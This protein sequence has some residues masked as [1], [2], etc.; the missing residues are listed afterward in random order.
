MNPITPELRQAIERAGDRPVVITDPEIN[1]AYV[2]VRAEV[3][4]Q[5]QSLIAYDVGP[6]TI[7]EQKALLTHAGKIT[8]WDDP[9]MDVYN[10]LDP[11]KP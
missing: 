1:I 9:A 5:M 11:R 2:L 4:K 3:F 6:L 8:G 10:E 7:E